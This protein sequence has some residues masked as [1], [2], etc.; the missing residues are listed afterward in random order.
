MPR[1]HSHQCNDKKT[2]RYKYTIFVLQGNITIPI[3]L[4]CK[5][6][7]AVATLTVD[8][9]LD[10]AFLKQGMP[11]STKAERGAAVGQRNVRGDTS[12]LCS[13]MHDFYTTFKCS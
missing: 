8:E 4:V 1:P 3:F 10:G 6:C 5:F 12:T 7:C 2:F 13:Q 11:A 9:L